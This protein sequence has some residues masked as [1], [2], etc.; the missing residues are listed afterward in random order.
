MK[1]LRVITSLAFAFAAFASADLTAQE[2][3]ALPGQTAAKE[4]A[5]EWAE[6]F[7]GA[8]LPTVWQSARAAVEKIATA[9]AAQD[10]SVV[11]PLAETAHLAAHALL[12]QVKLDDPERQKRLHATLA[13]A[14]QLADDVM[15]AARHNDSAKLGD[16]FPRLQAALQ[17]AA[18]RLPKEIVTAPPQAVRVAPKK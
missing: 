3:T 11:P 7:G 2:K 18:R 16:A 5:P 10:L 12:D 15:A 9:L 17:L 8:S 14:A 6:L 4:P 1:T 13:H